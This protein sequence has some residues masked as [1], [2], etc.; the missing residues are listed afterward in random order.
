MLRTRKLLDGYEPTGD[1]VRAYV[2]VRTTHS[3]TFRF[4]KGLQ[5]TRFAT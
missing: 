4:N 3:Q 5:I 2:H 1:T